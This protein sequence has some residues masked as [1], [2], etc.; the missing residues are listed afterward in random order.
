MQW[1]NTEAIVVARL[2]LG[3]SQNQL[4]RLL[5]WDP[6]TLRAVEEKGKLTEQKMLAL[7]LYLGLDIQ[8]FFPGKLA[9][10]DL[11]DFKLGKEGSSSEGP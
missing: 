8:Q 11:D 4:A 5:G 2:Q 6:R 10:V 7:C 3:Y 9:K 1:E